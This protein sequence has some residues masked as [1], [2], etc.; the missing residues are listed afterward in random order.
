MRWVE[1]VVMPAFWAIRSI[2]RSPRRQAPERKA[3][4]CCGEKARA[5]YR[6][7]GGQFGWGFRS[8]RPCSH[9]VRGASVSRIFARKPPV[10]KPPN[11]R[12]NDHLADRQLSEMGICAPLGQTRFDRTSVPSRPVARSRAHPTTPTLTRTASAAPPASPSFARVRARVRPGLA[13]GPWPS[14]RA[15]RAGRSWRCGGASR[16]RLPPSAGP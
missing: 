4:P 5:R 12:H 2:L 10:R 16:V 11:L 14:V 15:R 13:P 8:L 3:G 7:D 6:A 9:S 1:I